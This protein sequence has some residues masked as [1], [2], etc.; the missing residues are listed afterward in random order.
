MIEYLSLTQVVPEATHV[1]PKGTSTLIDLALAS[2]PS[3]L[4]D[5]EVIPPI[6]NSDHNGFRLCG[7][8][9]SSR[10]ISNPDQ[11]GDSIL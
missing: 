8:Q 2:A 9:A 4:H 3:L 6:W 1:T 5:C 7:S 10:Y 11:Y